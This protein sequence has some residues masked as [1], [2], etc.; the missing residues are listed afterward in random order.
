MRLLN[1]YLLFSDGTLFLSTDYEMS[2]QCCDAI[3]SNKENIDCVANYSLSTISICLN[4]WRHGLR[5][6][7]NTTDMGDNMSVSV[8]SFPR[9]LFRRGHPPKKKYLNNIL[10]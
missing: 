4:K 10:N 3:Y 8:L 2:L 5:L 6:N 1:Q 9:L 7:A